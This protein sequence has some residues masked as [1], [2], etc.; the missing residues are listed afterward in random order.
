MFTPCLTFHAIANGV[1]LPFFR[2]QWIISVVGLIVFLVGMLYAEAAARLVRVPLDMKPWFVLA[3][4]C[5]NLISLPLVLIEAICREGAHAQGSITKCIDQATTR[6][7]TVCL[8]NNLAFW[9]LLQSYAKYYV[10]LSAQGRAYQGVKGKHVGDV[11]ES[12]GL[13]Y[14]AGE[15]SCPVDCIEDEKQPLPKTLGLESIV[16]GRVDGDGKSAD[17]GQANETKLVAPNSAVGQA[18]SSICTGVLKAFCEPPAIASIVGLVFA[19]VEPAHR[20]L[21]GRGAPASF[22]VSVIALVGKASPSCGAIVVGGSFGLL[23][24]QLK[25]SP[26][27]RFDLAVLGVSWKHVLVVAFSRIVIVPSIL[28]ALFIFSMDAMPNDYLSRLV[29]FFQP[30]GITANVISVLAQLLD[31]PDAAQ[32]IAIVTIPQIL[33]YV[34]TSTVLIAMGMAW[35]S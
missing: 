23:L 9:T 7:F 34:P 1:S 22:V 11:V 8:W 29:L 33:L 5:P 28:L 12:E 31:Q 26:K 6:L 4:A 10:N 21:Y 30:A 19:F 27:E 20:L 18:D 32:F 15:Y 3:I 24:L 17:S 35:G 13:R 14:G 25:G 2:E 16:N